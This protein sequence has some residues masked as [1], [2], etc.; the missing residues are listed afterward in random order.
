MDG[1]EHA[2]LV[3]NCGSSSLKFALI[4]AE[5]GKRF[6]SGLAQRLGT[7]EAELTGTVAGERGERAIP[8]AGHG[9]AL[10]AIMTWLGTSDASRVRPV[11]VGHRV[12]HGGEYF[13]GPALLDDAA[14]ERIE[15]C[16]RFAPLHN[17][18]NVTGIRIARAF[19]PDVPQVGVFDTA[20]HQTMPDAAFHY[21]I[22]HELYEKHRLR[23]YGFHGTSHEYVAR[24]TAR[25]IGKPPEETNLIVAHL[26]NGCSVCAVAGGR[27]VDTSMG[28]TPLDGLMMGTRSGS[29]D[30][31]LHLT[32][33]ELEGLDL[34]AI[35]DLLNRGSG[36]LG[37][38]GVSNDMRAI[39][40][41]VGLGH[42]RAD[43]ARRMFV[44]RLAKEILAMAAGLER[45]DAL[46]FTA[47]IGEN[48][49]ATRAATLGHLR[50]WNPE[51]DPDLNATHGAGAQG[52]IT[53]ES[54]AGLL[55]MVV[56]TDEELMIARAALAM[57]PTAEKAPA[58]QPL[59]NL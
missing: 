53:R 37:V 17:P 19:F 10:E 20:F 39:E 31:N 41:E 30:P 12:V 42:A 1:I 59:L 6:A 13:S 4:G 16:A 5:S 52:R 58:S 55:A 36:L 23:R 50:V 49:A 38:S 44:Y 32:L 8:G 15:E 28:L 22:P 14:I 46:V 25:R 43:L 9:E 18:A 11:A 54:S 34:A 7:A 40:A 51:L 47:G 35:T 33:H 48:S 24:E 3:I 57:V 29:V 45:V 2:A 21:A 26:G 27:S 56:P